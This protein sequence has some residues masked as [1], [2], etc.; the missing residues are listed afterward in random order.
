SAVPDE[1]GRKNR[2]GR[3]WRHAAIA[4]TRSTLKLR[5]T[6]DMKQLKIV[7]SMLLMATVALGWRLTSTTTR[8]QRYEGM[9]LET[10]DLSNVGVLVHGPDSVG[11]NDKLSSLLT[12][13]GDLAGDAAKYSLIIENKTPQHINAISVIWRFYP[14]EGKP[15]EHK[16]EYSFLSNS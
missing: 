9:Q 8:K 13:P 11:F 5:I 15:I 7:L 10:N 2:G 6:E 3:N 12:I 16:Y 4:S 1:Q 14:S